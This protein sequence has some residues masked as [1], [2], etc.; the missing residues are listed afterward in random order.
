[1]I[2]LDN[3][4]PINA[5]DYVLR[6][7]DMTYIKNDNIIYVGTAETLNADFIDSKAL[8]KFNLKYISTET[9]SSQLSALGINVQ[10][11]KVDINL[12]EFWISGYPME[13][14]KTNE[15]IKTI[16]NKKNITVGSASISSYL[17]AIDLKYIDEFSVDKYHRHY[18]PKP[19]IQGNH[20]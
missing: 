5:I 3:V 16:D 14:A 2:T 17:S 6:M 11:V 8:T 9:L 18:V 12:R 13:L 19:A 15:L 20:D 4:S 1:M 10:I 7:V